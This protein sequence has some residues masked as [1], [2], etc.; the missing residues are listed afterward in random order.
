LIHQVL[1]E[2]ERHALDAGIP[3]GGLD[4]ALAVLERVFEHEASFGS[5][6]LNQAWLHKGRLLLERMYNNWPG[7]DAVPIALEHHLELEIDGNR[8]HG[9]S[10][11]IE[12]PR[13]NELRIVDY[14]TSKTPAPEAEAR[15]SLQLGFYLLAAAS[16]PVLAG[17]GVPAEAELWYP[18]GEARRVFDASN[19]ARVVEELVRIGAAI[20]REDW[21]AQP[22][23][24]CGRCSLRLV[25]PAWP[26]GR[27]G[28]VA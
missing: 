13:R 6:V 14:K 20:A 10:D 12:V 19:L 17:H 24:D 18:L 11:R 2:V 7:G 4:R 27:E 28:F 21:T 16:D 15:T 22:G 8:W 25:C 26:E 5:P 1:E 3:N 9:Y 23:P